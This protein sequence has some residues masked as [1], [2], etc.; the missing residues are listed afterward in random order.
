MYQA[1]I[2]SVFSQLVLMGISYGS[3]AK[4]LNSLSNN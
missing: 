3:I 4:A 2:F 1:S